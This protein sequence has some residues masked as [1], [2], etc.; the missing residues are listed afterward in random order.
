M[1]EQKHI[2]WSSDVDY[3]DWRADLE[4][5]YAAMPLRSGTGCVF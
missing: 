1:N 4:E 5:Q 2:I 3:E